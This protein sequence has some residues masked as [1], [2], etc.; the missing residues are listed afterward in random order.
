MRFKVY[1]HNQMFE[2][3]YYSPAFLCM[4]KQAPNAV[5][6]TYFTIGMLV[7]FRNNHV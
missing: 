4:C 7:F 3:D 5:S 6:T 1:L 2:S